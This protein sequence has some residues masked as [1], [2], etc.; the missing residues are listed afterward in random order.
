[1]TLGSSSNLAEGKQNPEDL[2][3]ML[4]GVMARNGGEG[5]KTLANVD[6]SNVNFWRS[7]EDE[8]AQGTFRRK[9]AVD[10]SKLADLL[11]DKEI[12][13]EARVFMPEVKWD[14]EMVEEVTDWVLTYHVDL[15]NSPVF[16]RSNGR[17][18][19]FPLKLGMALDK[20][21][22]KEQKKEIS[23]DIREKINTLIRGACFFQEA[24]MFSNKGI[25]VITK[26]EKTY[27]RSLIQ[28]RYHRRVVRKIL[29][30][31]DQLDEM[32]RSINP[33]LSKVEAANTE[34]AAENNGTVEGISN[35]IRAIVEKEISEF[36]TCDLDPV[37]VAESLEPA[38]VHQF[39]TQVFFSGDGDFGTLY[40]KLYRAKKKVVVVS[41]ED[42]LA[43]NVF[44]L[45][46]YGVVTLYKPST[47][48]LIWRRLY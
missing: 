16:E 5:S 41:P 36:Q 11:T 17:A 47:V 37:I 22:T 39:N 48:D 3:T 18:N 30:K 43:G 32:G 15:L 20:Y 24:Q 10:Y 42:M 34:I 23:E 31:L 45:A 38:T 25:R 6:L 12:F 44:S 9:Y 40:R 33:K 27:R 29:K 1:M 26:K 13:S 2:K 19:D 46:N 28:D 8:I 21:L 14:S 35:S 4:Q 7:W